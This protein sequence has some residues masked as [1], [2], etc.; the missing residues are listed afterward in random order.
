MTTMIPAATTASMKT[1]PAAARI[2][3]MTATAT[4]MM[5]TTTGTITETATMMATLTTTSTLLKLMVLQSG[6]I[7]KNNNVDD[8]TDMFTRLYSFCS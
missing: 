2:T 3:T 1:I 6:N 8:H 7:N 4:P 5:A